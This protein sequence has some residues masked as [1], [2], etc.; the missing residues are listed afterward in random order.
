M[1]FDTFK[2]GWT[3]GRCSSKTTSTSSWSCFI[4]VSIQQRAKKGQRVMFKALPF[5]PHGKSQ[6]NLSPPAQRICKISM[7]L[8]STGWPW[9][10]ASGNW[11]TSGLTLKQNRTVGYC[12]AP[13]T[14]FGMD[15]RGVVG[16]D[17]GSTQTWL[18]GTS[19]LRQFGGLKDTEHHSRGR[20]AEG[21]RFDLCKFRPCE[22]PQQKRRLANLPIA[23]AVRN[24]MSGFSR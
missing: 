8:T 21:M 7:E 15:G 11:Q 9:Q 24:L 6:K 5:I 19:E 3:G 10:G 1:L 4:C 18:K 14:G 20:L 23:E 16:W 2:R 13:W 12:S 17:S 22:K